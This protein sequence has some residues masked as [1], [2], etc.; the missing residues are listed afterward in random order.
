MYQHDYTMVLTDKPA[1]VPL[2]STMI[3]SKPSSL[4]MSTPSP[5]ITAGSTWH[6]EVQVALKT[7]FK[8]SL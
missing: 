6:G 2:V 8:R 3:I 7:L 4:N 5:A 1:A